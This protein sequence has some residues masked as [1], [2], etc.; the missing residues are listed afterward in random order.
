M[1]D[2]GVSNCTIA[3]IYFKG[4]DA[5]TQHLPTPTQVLSMLIAQLCWNLNTLPLDVL[6]SYREMVRNAR[7]PQFKDLQNILIECARSLSKVVLVFDG[8]DECEEFYRKQILQFICTVGAHCANVK[9]FVTS[10]WMHD[11]AYTFSRLQALKI[12]IG[13]YRVIKDLAEVVR[14][15]VETD[16]EHI[17]RDLQLEVMQIL[18]EKSSGM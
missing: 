14:H 9:V 2:S 11:I 5:H 6:K 8:V 1:R 15:R 7:K 13:R 17:S 10:R 16:L 3:Y 4:E 12:E 18:T